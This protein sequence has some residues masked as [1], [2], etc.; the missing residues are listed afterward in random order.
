MEQK[1]NGDKNIELTLAQQMKE[2]KQQKDHVEGIKS[3][4]AGSDPCCRFFDCGK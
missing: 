3:K 1:V 4:N 2:T